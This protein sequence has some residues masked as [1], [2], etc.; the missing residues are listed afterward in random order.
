MSNRSA[1]NALSNQKQIPAR[2]TKSNGFECWQ[3][4]LHRSKAASYNLCEV[5]KN[6]RSG[7]VLIQEPWTY[8]GAIRSKLRGWKLFQGNKK[9]KR[10]RACIYVTSDITCSLLYH[11]FLAK[12]W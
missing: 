6:I 10:P 2:K 5:T 9:D 7:I 12:M 3:I 4:N 1:T 11:N 8:G